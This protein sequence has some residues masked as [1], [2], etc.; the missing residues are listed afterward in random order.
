MKKLGGKNLAIQYKI[1]YKKPFQLVHFYRDFFKN[2]SLNL[3]TSVKKNGKK[4]GEGKNLILYFYALY[5][6]ANTKLGS[7]SVDVLFCNYDKVTPL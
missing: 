4:V 1:Q 5:A 7:V 6:T 2:L 3:F